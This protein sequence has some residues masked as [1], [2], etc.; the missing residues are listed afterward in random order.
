MLNT[1]INWRGDLIARSGMTFKRKELRDTIH[2]VDEEGVANRADFLKK[3]IVRYE[4][5]LSKFFYLE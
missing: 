3:R 1:S 4:K 5:S 2:R